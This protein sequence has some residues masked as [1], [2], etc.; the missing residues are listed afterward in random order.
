MAVGLAQ[1]NRLLPT[2]HRSPLLCHR[3]VHME[4]K[5]SQ[6]IKFGTACAHQV[7][8]SVVRRWLC[9]QEQPSLQHALVRLTSSGLFEGICA[10]FM[11]TL[12]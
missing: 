11:Q 2:T 5:T 7:A 9:R 8:E 1:G 3:A 12:G 4:Y 10:R 6:E